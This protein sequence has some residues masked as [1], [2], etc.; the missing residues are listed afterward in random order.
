[1]Q[2]ELGSIKKDDKKFGIKKDNIKRID[3]MNIDMFRKVKVDEI[4]G[5]EDTIMMIVKKA[6]EKEIG[7]LDA[8]KKLTISADGEL[9]YDGERF[10]KAK[11]IFVV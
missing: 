2:N 9:Y 8:L 4:P 11:E 1:M 3:N 6:I 5:G 7:N 10:V